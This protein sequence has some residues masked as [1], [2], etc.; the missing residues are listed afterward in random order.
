MLGFLDEVWWSRFAHPHL[1][2]WTDAQPLR[3]IQQEPRKDDPDPKA[4]ACYGLLRRDQEQVWLRFVDGRP[5]SAVTIAFLQWSLHRLD[6]E[7]KQA[8]L[9]IWDNASWH[10]SH[11]VRDWV[12]AHNRQVRREGGVRLVVCPLPKQSPWLNAIEPHWVHGKR[13]VLEPD[14]PLT[15]AELQQRLCAYFDCELLNPIAQSPP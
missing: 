5:V 2:A 3:L 6:R 13:A 14:R 15:V 7:G 10:I 1:H 12:A 9:L 8:L 11:A 4:V